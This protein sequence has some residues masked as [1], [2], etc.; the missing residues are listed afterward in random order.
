MSWGSG[1]ILVKNAR[2]CVFISS[3]HPF[4]QVLIQSLILMSLFSWIQSVRAKFIY[5][6][7]LI[8]WTKSPGGIIFSKKKTVILIDVSIFLRMSKITESIGNC[9]SLVEVQ[10]LVFY[11]LIFFFY[12]FPEGLHSSYSIGK[13]NHNWNDNL[14]SYM[15][16]VLLICLSRFSSG[17]GWFLIKFSV[18]IARDIQ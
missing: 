10:L 13:L 1:R 11:P 5:L 14:F 18:R 15:R 9:H 16:W 6:I 8:L 4:H 3:H 12:L 2:A 17:A 7:Q